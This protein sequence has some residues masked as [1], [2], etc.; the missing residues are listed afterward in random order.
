MHTFWQN[1]H[2][3]HII[4]YIFPLP[5]FAFAF[6]DLLCC[7]ATFRSVATSLCRMQVEGTVS[8]KPHSINCMTCLWQVTHIWWCWERQYGSR[9]SET[10]FIVYRC[11]FP[12]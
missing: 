3:M 5:I 12:G 1:E 2:C 9:S 8:L 11:T 6:E 4:I 10:S 7:C